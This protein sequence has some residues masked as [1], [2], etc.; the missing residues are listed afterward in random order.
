MFKIQKH[1]YV[2]IYVITRFV[3]IW[4]DGRMVKDM[5]YSYGGKGLNLFFYILFK[6]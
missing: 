1:T 3:I 4:S 6:I 2:Y 5:S